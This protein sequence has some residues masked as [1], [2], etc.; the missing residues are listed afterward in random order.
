MSDLCKLSLQKFSF[1]YVQ[2]LHN[3]CSHIKDVHLLFS[4]R[5]MNIYFLFL[6]VLNIDIFPLRMLVWYMVCITP[7][8]SIP[9]YSNF[10]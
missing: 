5:F 2:A 1:L 4:A 8:V 7:T 10:A 9:L 6:G 3:N